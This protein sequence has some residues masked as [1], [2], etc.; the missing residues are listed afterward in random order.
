MYSVY[1]E[2][3]FLRVCT[4]VYVC[5]RPSLMMGRTS[6][7][8]ATRCH[9]N[10]RETRNTAARNKI[11]IIHTLRLDPKMGSRA[12]VISTLGQM[13]QQDLLEFCRIMVYIITCV[14]Q[15]SHVYLHVFICLLHFII[16]S[17]R[18]KEEYFNNVFYRNGKC[19]LNAEYKWVIIIN[20]IRI[21]NFN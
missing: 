2:Q 17:W 18:Q 7:L 11:S 6:Q 10:S 13:I 4:Y 3:S 14:R 21:K 1:G 19:I 9:F 12:T 16:A 20:D 15:L 5:V 8:L